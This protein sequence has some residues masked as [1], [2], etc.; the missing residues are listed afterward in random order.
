[1]TEAIVAARTDTVRLQGTHMKGRQ[2]D[3]PTMIWLPELTEPAENFS[4]FFGDRKNKI[5]DV[6][7][8]WML[9]YRNQ[10][11]SDHHESYDMEVSGSLKPI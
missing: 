9:N 3:L 2:P 4:K 11:E 8:V 6:R 1:M 7:N 10:G 5:L